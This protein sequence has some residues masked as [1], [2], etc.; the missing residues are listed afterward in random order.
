MAPAHDVARA[1]TF[2]RLEHPIDRKDLNR[3][4]RA[5]V[6]HCIASDSE[7]PAALVLDI[8][9]ADD[10]TYGQQ[11]FAF[12][13]HPSQNH[14]S[15]PLFIFAG[16]SQALGTASLRPGTRPPGAENAMLVVRLL[17]YLRRHW[18]HPHLLVRG[19]RHFATPAGIDVITTYRWTD[20]V[21]GL[22]GNAVLLRQA[23]PTL[24]E[25]RRLPHQRVAPAQA[26]GQTPPPRSRLSDACVSAT[27]AWAQ[28]WRGILKAEVMRAGEPPALWGPRWR[29]PEALRRPLWRPWPLRKCSQGGAA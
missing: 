6:D 14:G 1:P 23:A 11:E 16:T 19:D 17:S 21:F 12:S 22:A 18:P 2:S 20:F 24:Q 28:P 4:T 7:P 29:P 9:H 10:P 3:L 27:G 13:N 26:H 15:L 25:A 8:D 5:L